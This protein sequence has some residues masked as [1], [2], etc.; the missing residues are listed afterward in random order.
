ML[1]IVTQVTKN[2]SWML[3]TIIQ[4]CICQI[5][6]KETCSI[7]NK[8][9]IIRERSIQWQFLTPIKCDKFFESKFCDFLSST[10]KNNCCLQSNVFND[11]LILNFKLHKYKCLHTKFN[12]ISTWVIIIR[13]YEKKCDLLETYVKKQSKQSQEN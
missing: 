9:L 1:L 2:T 8:Y 5:L 10:N 11:V 12:N 4:L 7:T 6:G 13:V 3:N